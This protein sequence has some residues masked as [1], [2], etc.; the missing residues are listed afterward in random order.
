MNS[1]VINF[2]PVFSIGRRR[3]KG[4]WALPGHLQFSIGWNKWRQV[5][6]RKDGHMLLRDLWRHPL[7]RT[8]ALRQRIVLL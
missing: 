1:L 3:S 5:R 6:K 8:F 4:L 2:S 7:S